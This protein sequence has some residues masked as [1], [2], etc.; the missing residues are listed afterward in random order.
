MTPESAHTGI[1]II[2][3]V[4]TAGLD[5]VISSRRHFEQLLECLPSVIT[6]I[7]MMVLQLN[8]QLRV[9]TLNPCF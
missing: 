8:V 6:I 3:W 7:M 4:V 5:L 1:I 9:Y 2:D